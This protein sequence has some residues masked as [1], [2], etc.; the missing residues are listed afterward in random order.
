M[1]WKQTQLL[2]PFVSYKKSRSDLFETLVRGNWNN[3][4]R[5]KAVRVFQ[6]WCDYRRCLA[7]FVR[8]DCWRGLYAR[9]S[10]LRSRVDMLL[11]SSAPNSQGRACVLVLMRLLV[12]FGFVCPTW[13][14]TWIVCWVLTAVIPGPH[15]VRFFESSRGFQRDQLGA[16][17]NLCGLAL[18]AHGYTERLFY[19]INGMPSSVG[20]LVRHC[21]F[22]PFVQTGKILM[23]TVLFRSL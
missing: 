18:V 21:V 4:C 3:F 13:L 2:W 23:A 7:L 6:F 16:R 11:D 20:S 19:R 5:K 10:P 12:V 17:G 9:C 15:A 8:L 1:E 14:L 22:A